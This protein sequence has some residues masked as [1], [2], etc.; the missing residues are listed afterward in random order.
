MRA[1]AALAL[2]AAAL[3][4]AATAQVYVPPEPTPS[5]RERLGQS[6]VMKV[7]LANKPAIVKCVN[8][9]KKKDPSSSGKLVMRWTI[10]TNGKTKNVSVH[11][12]EF[13]GTYMAS[14]IT[15]LVKGWTFPKH[16]KQG[17]PIEFPFTF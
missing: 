17:D 14:C 7:V 5:Q 10:Q 13:A 16:T 2:I 8:E 11:S 15:G 1:C 6:D 4:F 12:P 9:Q 3:P